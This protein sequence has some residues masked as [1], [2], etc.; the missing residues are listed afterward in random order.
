[1]SKVCLMCNQELSPKARPTRYTVD[2]YPRLGAPEHLYLCASCA[3]KMAPT[4]K[5]VIKAYEDQV[6]HTS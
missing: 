3:K 4:L 6:L 2:E 5:T 1:M